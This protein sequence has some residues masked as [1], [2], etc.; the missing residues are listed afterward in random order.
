MGRAN[1]CFGKRKERRS[2]KIK[3]DLYTYHTGIHLAQNAFTLYIVTLAFGREQE[4]RAR[5]IWGW[6]IVYKIGRM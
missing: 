5:P 2:H 1:S 3:F 4:S 6:A